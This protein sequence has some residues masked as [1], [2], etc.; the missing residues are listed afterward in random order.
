MSREAYGESGN[1]VVPPEVKDRYKHFGT[2]A[3]PSITITLKSVL[4]FKKS[5]LLLYKI[6][7]R[8]SELEWYTCIG[9]WKM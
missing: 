7:R 1:I 3:I 2:I 4:L 6:S 5:H 9:V 8:K